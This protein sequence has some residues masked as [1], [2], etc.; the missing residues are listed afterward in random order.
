[1]SG[2]TTDPTALTVRAG[3]CHRLAE[4]T[5]PDCQLAGV[6]ASLA[7]CTSL[8]SLDLSGNLLGMSADLP[9]ALATGLVNLRELNVARNR[10]VAL[11]AALGEL[12]AL[13]RLDCRENQLRAIPKSVDGCASLAELYLGQNQITSVPESVGG[14]S[15]LRVLFCFLSSNRF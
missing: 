13:A 10:L 8:V 2:S 7:R 14:E 11:P 6:P 4:L 12:K 5:A 1:M 9:E 3:D 15:A